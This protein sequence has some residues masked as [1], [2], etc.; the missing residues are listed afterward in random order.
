[1][2]SFFITFEGGEGSGKT[3]QIARLAR[4]LEAQGRI[5]VTT[6]EPGGSP[7]ADA[8]RH[9]ILSGAAEELGPEVEAIL[10]AAARADHVAAVIRPAIQRGEVVLC[11]RFHD[12]TRVYQFLDASL[13]RDLMKRLEQAATAGLYPNLTII[14]DVP[15]G[16]GAER[17]RERRKG[18]TAD[19]F[20]KEGE[21]LHE[22][23]RQ[24]FLKIAAE[25]P[26]RCVVVDGTRAED[27]VAA[28][29]AGIVDDRLEA[30]RFEAICQSLNARQGTS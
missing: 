6:R 10:F 5:V 24:A 19:R 21:A 13:D 29:I 18:G 3:T 15:A 16:I 1:M 17:A 28:E 26:D 7:G 27:V 23:R 11:D 9:V 25:E 4:H 30:A 20:E 12:S 14:L 8:I 22:R 2:T